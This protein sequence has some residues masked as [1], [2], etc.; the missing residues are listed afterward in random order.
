VSDD[1][2]TW[3]VVGLKSCEEQLSQ[4]VD[5][6]RSVE[7]P[8]EIVTPDALDDQPARVTLRI[9]HDRVVAAVLALEQHGFKRLKAYTGGRPW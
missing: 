2:A 6:L 7:V 4:V 9:P 1:E 8:A 5:I 3:L